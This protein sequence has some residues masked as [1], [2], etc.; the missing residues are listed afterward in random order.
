MHRLASPPLP[1][2]RALASGVAMAL[3]L[4]LLGAC[5]GTPFGET[6]SRSFSPPQAGG[7]AATSLPPAAAAGSSPAAAPAPGTPASGGAGSSAPAPATPAA[8]PRRGEGG[9]AGGSGADASAPAARGSVPKPP[10]VAAAVRPGGATAP[11]RVTIRLPLADPSA[12]AE[13]VTEALRSAGVAFE[14]E[15][16][17]RMG[18]G[19]GA[20]A[21]AAPA[22]PPQVRPAPPPR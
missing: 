22:G 11:Y 18:G 20:G 17:E 16:I 13:V 10:A 6:L 9:N 4:P 8:P 14:V 19:A 5:S 3:L 21:G 2:L 12:P 1:G 15:T 7:A